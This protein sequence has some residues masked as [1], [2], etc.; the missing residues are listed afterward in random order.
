MFGSFGIWG[1][2]FRV[3][4]VSGVRVRVLEVE[5][6][7]ANPMGPVRYTVKT[8]KT[9]NRRAKAFGNMQAWLRCACGDGGWMSAR[10]QV[11]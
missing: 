3:Y 2:G 9:V 4:R 6:L 11:A 10:M 5:T 1:F 8:P 7:Q